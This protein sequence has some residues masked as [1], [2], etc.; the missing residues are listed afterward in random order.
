[1]RSPLH[2]QPY[3]HWLLTRLSS[4]LYESRRYALALRYEEKAFAQITGCLLVLW[5]YAVH[6]ARITKNA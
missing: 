3:H 2:G 4:V 6:R 5:D 1:M